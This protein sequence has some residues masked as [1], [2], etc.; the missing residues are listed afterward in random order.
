MG[1][2]F[3]EDFSEVL[4]FEPEGLY[5]AHKLFTEDEALEKFREW[6]EVHYGE[7]TSKI[8][9]VTIGYVK[10]GFFTEDLREDLGTDAGWTSCNIDDR[11]SQTC[12]IIR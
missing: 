7:A 1:K 6:E 9:D 11:N 10:Y 4:K 5:L 3:L 2:R 12:W 8:T